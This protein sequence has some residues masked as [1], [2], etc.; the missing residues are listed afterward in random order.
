MLIENVELTLANV[1]LGR[2]SEVP[3]LALFATAQAHHLT[4]GTGHTL[5]Q[6]TDAD[7]TLLYPGYFWLHVTVPPAQPLERFRVWDQVAV[8]VD[9]GRYGGL[10]LESRYALGAPG[11]VG[12]DPAAWSA[13][14]SMHAASMWV[15]DGSAVVQPARPRDGAVAELPSLKCGPPALE[16]FRRMRAS[17]TFGHAPD[18]RHGT[19]P[20]AYD[21]SL[22]RDVAPDH[23]LMFAAYVQIIESLEETFLRSGMWPALPADLLGCRRL[24]EREVFFLDHAGPGAKIVG[25]LRLRILPCEPNAH[26]ADPELSSAGRLESTCELYDAR[27]NALLTCARAVKL[28]VIP[29]SRGTLVA[30]LTRYQENS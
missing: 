12:E 18:A 16:A 28:F 9:V 17:G 27:T 29:R 13:L 11:E 24:V 23:N 7:G 6:V 20:I 19:L 21:V 26:G 22:G 15:V 1:G 10:V 8:G 3:L 4:A 14:P 30:D 5:H 25:D 2:L